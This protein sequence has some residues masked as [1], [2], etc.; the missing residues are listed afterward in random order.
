MQLNLKLAKA[1]GP[2]GTNW[3]GRAFNRR[4]AKKKREF[5]I[6]DYQISRLILLISEARDL[7][8]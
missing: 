6:R 1:S 2:P 5:Y 3:I 8:T 4:E 7:W